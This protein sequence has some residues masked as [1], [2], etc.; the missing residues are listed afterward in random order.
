MDG[1]HSFIDWQTAGLRA[2]FIKALSKKQVEGLH[3]LEYTRGD[4][5][6]GESQKGNNWLIAP[7]EIKSIFYAD[8]K[9]IT[10]GEKEIET[11]IFCIKNQVPK[12]IE[13]EGSYSASVEF[14]HAWD[15]NI[16]NN[17]T[18]RG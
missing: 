4:R 1:K 14:Q 2:G 5:Y 6:Y 7:F 3:K 13:N 9:D 15:W 10:I 16:Y 8:L 18:L 11:I 17:V 12:G